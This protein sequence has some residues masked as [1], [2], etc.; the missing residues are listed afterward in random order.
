MVTWITTYSEMEYSCLH[1]VFRVDGGTDAFLE[2]VGEARATC[3]LSRVMR[4]QPVEKELLAF[5]KDIR[6]SFEI[7]VS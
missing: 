6:F 7:G 5:G 4:W 2:L 3:C 1:L